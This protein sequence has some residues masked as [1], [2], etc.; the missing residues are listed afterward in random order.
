MTL[1]TFD[2]MLCVGAPQGG[3]TNK[4]F[5]IFSM[6]KYQIVISTHFCQYDT[7]L[8]LDINALQC[9]AQPL[10]LKETSSLI[11]P[12]NNGQVISGHFIFKCQGAN[13]AVGAMPPC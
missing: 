2:H 11:L 10:Y 1:D 7:K 6:V 13:I 4:N 9:L 5:M 8:P 12:S 3:L